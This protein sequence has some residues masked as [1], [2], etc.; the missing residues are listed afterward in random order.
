MANILLTIQR[1]TRDMIAA[2]YGQLMRQPVDYGE[3]FYE[4]VWAY[5]ASKCRLSPYAMQRCRSRLGLHHEDK[6][7]DREIEEEYFR[8][9]N[10]REKM[11]IDRLRT[12]LMI[13]FQQSHAFPWRGG[14]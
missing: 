9:V 7:W 5:A 13:N 11:D 14:L 2:K 3:Q 10:Q 8:A 4:H 12:R 1:I 6:H